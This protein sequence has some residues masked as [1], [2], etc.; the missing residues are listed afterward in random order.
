MKK[1]KF[2]FWD[3]EVFDYEMGIYAHGDIADL[4]ECFHNHAGENGEYY[5]AQD[6]IGLS[7]KTGKD[8]FAG[9]IIRLQDNTFAKIEWDNDRCRYIAKWDKTNQDSITNCVDMTR[10]I[11]NTSEIVGNIHQL[12]CN[13]DHNAECL[14]CD[15]WPDECQLK[16]LIE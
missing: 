1:H 7:D 13:F 2:R 14:V 16:P 10:D 12:P 8:I 15:C 9:D 11:A 3:G 5:T 6:F 4:S